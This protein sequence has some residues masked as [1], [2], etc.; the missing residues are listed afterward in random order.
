MTIGN[1]EY[2]EILITDEGGGLIASITDEDIVEEKSCKV[3]CV[4]TQ[5]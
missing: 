3:V 2:S 1:K 5:D 4:P